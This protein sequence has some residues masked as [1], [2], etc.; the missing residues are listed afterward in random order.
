MKAYRVRITGELLASLFQKGH[1][2]SW[3]GS[4]M[5]VSEGIPDGVVLVAVRMGNPNPCLIE[6]LWIHPDDTHM[7]GIDM[8]QEAEDVDVTIKVRQ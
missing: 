3:W 7:E 4:E 8:W 5:R 1:V 2:I 6:T